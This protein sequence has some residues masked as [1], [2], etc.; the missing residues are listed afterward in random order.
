MLFFVGLLPATIFVVVG[1]FVLFAS[2]RADGVV[3]AFGRVLAVWIFVVAAVPPV[4][5]AYATFTGASPFKEMMA[6]HAKW[7]QTP[8]A[9]GSGG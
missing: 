9:I 1:Y 4:A 8:A 5:G 7:H 3:R 6:G 2:A